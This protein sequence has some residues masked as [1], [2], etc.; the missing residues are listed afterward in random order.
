[1]HQ[2]LR[3]TIMQ[4][5]QWAHE[6]N[7]HPNRE[8]KN[9]EFIE[10][11]LLSS[12]LNWTKTFVTQTE[13]GKEKKKNQQK[14]KKKYFFM[15]QNLFSCP[16]PGSSWGWPLLYIFFSEWNKT[17]K[18]PC[19]TSFN[20]FKTP[21]FVKWDTLKPLG[22]GKWWASD[23]APVP[24]HARCRPAPSLHQVCSAGLWMTKCCD[25]KNVLDWPIDYQYMQL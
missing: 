14:K 5:R 11:I 3:E 16:F 24:T 18:L 13:W 19:W 21:G 7:M 20:N 1:M 8:Q 23:L 25:S 9:P 4:Y 6:T 15:D 2:N 12:F 22:S 10:I 17:K